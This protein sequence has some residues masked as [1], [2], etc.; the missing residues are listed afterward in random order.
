M[1]G[2]ASKPPQRKFARD[3]DTQ[4]FSAKWLGRGKGTWR[5][6]FEEGHPGAH[7]D[8]MKREW[9]QRNARRRKP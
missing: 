6:Q 5:C 3:M 8:S 7:Q 2:S 1:N 9:Q 4:C